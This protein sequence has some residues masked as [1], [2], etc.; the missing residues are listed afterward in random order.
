MFF[1]RCMCVFWLAF[2]VSLFFPFCISVCVLWSAGHVCWFMCL[3]WMVVSGTCVSVCVCVVDGGHCYL[4]VGL[5][6]CCR[7]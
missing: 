2:V 5:C 4:C 3:L 1:V 7:W 6:V